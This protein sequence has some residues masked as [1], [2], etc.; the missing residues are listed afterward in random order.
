MSLSIK[1]TRLH[2]LIL[3][4]CLAGSERSA[5]A[6]T[7]THTAFTNGAVTEHLAWRDTAG[8][9][10]N[11]HDG[12]ILWADGKYHWYGMA[13][14]PLPAINGPD[15]GQKTTLGVIMY[16]S[17]DLY[18]WTYEGVVLACSTDPANPLHCPMRFERPKIL[19]NAHTKQYVMWFHYV[20]YP[21]DHGNT[22]GAGDAGVAVSSRVNGPYTF[23]GYSRPIDAK[24]IVRDCTLFQDDDGSAYFIYDR[25]VR[26]PGPG[27]GRV[28]HIV[29][30]TDDYLGFSN[31]WYKIANAERREAP[32]MI[33]RNGTYYLITS[34]ETGWKD[35]AANYYRATNIMGPYT[36]LGN[37][38][39]GPYADVTY[40]AQGTW[41]FSPH[42]HKH[43]VIF[44]AERHITSK[45]TDSSYIFLPVHF[46]A[47]STLTL[48]YRTSWQW[49]L[50]PH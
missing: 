15:G 1:N 24:G 19:Y 22:I 41:A 18:N 13:L 40:H 20:G 3:A 33:K 49:K 10:I 21:G 28:L 47:K 37:P 5:P 44:M 6:Q 8:N 25:D 14:R 30:L 2:W 35:N 50:W 34:A 39:S 48:P 17:T 42:G 38:T 23:K 31:K 36:E 46:G 32:V 26:E 9:L 11:A 27:F 7:Q 43:E 45:M 12:G 29:K 4:L 16:S